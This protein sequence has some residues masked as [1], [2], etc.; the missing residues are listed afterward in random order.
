M[1]SNWEN[2][3]CNFLF[4]HIIYFCVTHQG[5]KRLLEKEK[6]HL[7]KEGIYNIKAQALTQEYRCKIK[8]GTLNNR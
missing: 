7:L 1:F 4:H 8:D 6:N 2:E 3:L 5:L